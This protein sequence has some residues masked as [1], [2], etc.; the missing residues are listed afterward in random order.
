MR[1][2]SI[3]AGRGPSAQRFTLKLH[4]QPGASRS[5]IVGRHGDA[6]KVRIAAPAVDNRAN[7]ALVVLLSEALGIQKSAVVIRQG[8]SGRRKLVEIT[9]GPDMAARLAA[10]ERTSQKNE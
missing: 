7:A 3:P 10:L 2:S 4:V 5:E 6:L 1:D 8:A 9:G